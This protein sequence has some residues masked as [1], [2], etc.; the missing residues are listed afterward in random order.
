VEMPCN[1]WLPRQPIGVQMVCLLDFAAGVVFLLSAAVDW[2]R[3]GERR[4][5]RG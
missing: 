4:K 1:F 5:V 3:W 2:T